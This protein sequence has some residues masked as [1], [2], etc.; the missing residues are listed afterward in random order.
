VELLADPQAAAALGAAGRA[1]AIEEWGWDLQA[2]RLRE[3]LDQEG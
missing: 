3:L 2:R 1:W